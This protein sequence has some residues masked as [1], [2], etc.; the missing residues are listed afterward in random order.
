M[1]ISTP[2][3]IR[4]Y[5]AVVSDKEFTDLDSALRSIKK[6]LKSELNFERLYRICWN[7]V[8]GN[9]SEK[10]YG[11]LYNQLDALADEFATKWSS[12]DELL[13]LWT[14]FKVCLKSYFDISSYLHKN[15]VDRRR[16]DSVYII[17]YKL[18]GSK[19]ILPHFNVFLS[20]YQ[21]ISTDFFDSK[22]DIKVMT[23]IYDMVSNCQYSNDTVFHACEDHIQNW[24][25]TILERISKFSSAVYFE[26]LSRIHSI[27]L[28]HSKSVFS[29]EFS[30]LLIC[31]IGSY[32]IQKH[33]NILSMHISAT[34]DNPK[35][36]QQIYA[37]SLTSDT[38][39]N[40]LVDVF[41]TILQSNIS[42]ITISDKRRNDMI[43]YCSALLEVHKYASLVLVVFK[44]DVYLDANITST[45]SSFL[46]SNELSCESINVFFDVYLSSNSTAVSIEDCLLLF[47]YFQD[48][49]FFQLFYTLY[50]GKRL[51]GH[52]SVDFNKE[53]QVLSS[54]KM[55]C[56]AAYISKIEH[57]LQDV[58]LSN[59]FDSFGIVH[60]KVLTLASWPYK[61]QEELPIHI[62]PHVGAFESFYA[63]KHP[64]RKLHWNIHL[65]VAVMNVC[66]DKNYE[67][68]LSVI[69]MS[70][71]MLFNEKSNYSYSELLNR[72]GIESDEFNRHL[73]PC[74]L[75]KYNILLKSPPTKQCLPTDDF[76]VNMGFKNNAFRIKI[77]LLQ[78]NVKYLPV[79]E[80]RAFQIE[81]IIIRIMKTNKEM[82]HQSLMNEIVG[83]LES[84]FTVDIQSIKFCIEQL[85][86]RDFLQ[87]K[88]DN[89]NVYEY[90]A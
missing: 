26:E 33:P 17:G 24:L 83:T 2:I 50:L 51:L 81:A 9:Q 4:A 16:M 90:I 68:H 89:K 13:Q 79:V 74:C 39:K 76:K 38:L 40:Q 72:I 48:K 19:V 27:I 8:L 11:L 66:F 42:K 64:N 12:I 20:D 6:N 67:F 37:I 31:N 60:P 71:L 22:G 7:A 58:Q 28:E 47:K 69:Q 88:E 32:F 54:F 18:F 1:T 25:V 56:G 3:K 75:S 53:M 73:L 10:V 5:R 55:T 36:L 77:P 45:F 52:V 70:I 30:N 65:G 57:M 43:Q 14:D 49:D 63:L 23:S 85:I 41:V 86:E 80:D 84:M 46:K 44:N 29:S 15:F 61:I 87:R 62:L 78:S 59:E 35:L 34:M 21:R 82:A